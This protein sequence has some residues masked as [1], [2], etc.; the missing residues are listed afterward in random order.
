[1]REEAIRKRLYGRVTW[2]K[3]LQRRD[4]KQRR[5]AN[6]LSSVLLWYRGCD[7]KHE[8]QILEPRHAEPHGKWVRIMKISASY[9]L[10][11]TSEKW[12]ETMNIQR[13]VSTLPGRWV[14]IKT[15]AGK[16]SVSG[17]VRRDTTFCWGNLLGA[18]SPTT[19]YRDITCGKLMQLKRI[20]PWS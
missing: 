12:Y 9:Q 4:N 7:S 3:N 1:M 11:Y 14:A 2:S 20:G 18:C 19:L 15:P 10:H 5:P 17:N 13:S 16:A 6:Q 8:L